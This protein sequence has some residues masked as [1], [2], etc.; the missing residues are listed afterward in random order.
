[1][2]PVRIIATV[3]FV[4]TLALLALSSFECVTPLQSA[5]RELSGI[6]AALMKSC[7]VVGIEVTIFDPDKDPTGS[8]A[9]ELATA[10][11]RG[12]NA[13]SPAREQRI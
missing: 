12:L 13:A 4:A 11:A 2:R 9:R 7:R 3:V 10:L 5:A 6:L 1:M 8:I